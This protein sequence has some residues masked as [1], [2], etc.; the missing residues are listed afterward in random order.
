MSESGPK[1][2]KRT[3]WVAYLLRFTDDYKLRGEDPVYVSGPWLFSSEERAQAWAG[4]KLRAWVTNNGV[5]LPLEE[6]S[7]GDL[8]SLCTG[9]DVKDEHNYH[10]E[11]LQEAIKGEYVPCRIALD[12]E[13][14][15]IE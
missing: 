9:L 2:T 3:A 1:R 14:R 8:V 7:D 11:T 10:Y 12:I 6:L 13:E 15:V 4:K 5:D